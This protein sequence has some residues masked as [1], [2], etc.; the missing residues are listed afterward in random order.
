MQHLGE[1][2]SGRIAEQLLDMRAPEFLEE[3][4]RFRLVE[5]SIGRI[6]RDE[7]PVRSR[8]R[9]SRRT[10]QIVGMTGQSIQPQHPEERPKRTQ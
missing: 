7:E 2:I 4:R 6:N 8:P 5:L 9:E 1:L 10:K 3:A